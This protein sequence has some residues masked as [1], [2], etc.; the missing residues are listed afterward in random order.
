MRGIPAES[1]VLKKVYAQ[2]DIMRKAGHDVILAS[3]DDASKY[4]FVDNCNNVIYDI[5]IY[6]ISKFYKNKYVLDKTLQF[7]IEHNIKFV[8]S[9]FSDFSIDAYFFYRSLKKKGIKVVLEIPTYPIS[10]RW[11]SIKQS[12]K[13]GKIKASLTQIYNIIIGSSGIPFFK[14]ALDRIVNNNNFDFIWNIPVIKITNGIDLKSIPKR[15]HEYKC[16]NRITIFSVANVANWHGYDRIISGL[17]EYYNKPYEVE[18][19]FELVGQGIEAELL[20]KQVEKLKLEE[21]VKFWGT[22]IG[23]E[24][25]T[26]YENADIGVSVLG[27]HRNHF[28][29][30]DALKSREFCA[31]RLPFITEVSERHFNKKSFVL[32]VPSDDSPIKIDE[33][34]GFYNRIVAEP[35]ILEDMYEFAQNECDWSV[36]FQNVINYINSID[37]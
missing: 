5:P 19:V 16:K 8:Y 28:E 32:C 12:I 15:K 14:K 2:C 33:I 34:I 26:L 24:L 11:T 36:A 29:T 31:R 6:S 27:V 10:Q 21:Y 37:L 30:Y 7:V 9:R 17:W 3:L 35:T 23:Q 18:V 4:V 13:C 25:N 20:K 1:G 22:V